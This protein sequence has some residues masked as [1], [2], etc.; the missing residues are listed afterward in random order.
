MS[1]TAWLGWSK[2]RAMV[3]TGGTL[4]AY[5]G[6]GGTSPGPGMVEHLAPRSD[7]SSDWTAYRYQKADGH[8]RQKPQNNDN[9]TSRFRTETC[10]V[11]TKLPWRVFIRVFLLLDI[12]WH[13]FEGGFVKHPHSEGSLWW[14]AGFVPSRF[15]C[16]FGW[17]G[18]FAAGFLFFL[19]PLR[20]ESRRWAALSR[21][22]GGL[23]CVGVFFFF[24]LRYY[25]FTCSVSLITQLFNFSRRKPKRTSIC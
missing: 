14:G 15:F 19:K 10:A 18:D 17:L 21:N 12:I 24:L 2:Q 16:N 23:R 22:P 4:G 25:F 11:C 7:G 5:V 20:Q 3:Y 6:M 8:R 1:Y 9:D 13:Q